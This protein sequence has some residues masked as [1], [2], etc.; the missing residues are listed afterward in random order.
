MYG[1]KSASLAQRIVLAACAFAWLAVLW[2]LLAAGGL[3]H[4][5]QWFGQSWQAGNA[6]RR[7]LLGF[8]LTV[9]CLRLLLTEFVF[10]KRGVSWTEAFTIV[11][12]L[13]MIFLLLG[14]TGGTNENR[15][16]VIV[17]FGAVLFALGSWMNTQAEWSRHIWKQRTENHGH[18]Y[19][20]SWFRFTRHPNYLGDL[21]L[22]SGLSLVAGAWLCVVI[23][24]LMLVGFVFVNIPALDEH[25]Q[26]HYGQEF[27]EYSRK[28][29]KLVPFL[30]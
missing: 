30:Y 6:E 9:Y 18:L 4:A 29:K 7:W 23:P 8:C 28:T 2:W 12:W 5:G 17:V 20:G 1:V 10:L 13:L 21:L 19:T 3:T 25:L 14:I 15:A 26:E 27:E 16:G 11:P 22:F 24:M